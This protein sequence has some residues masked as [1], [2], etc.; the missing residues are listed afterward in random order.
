MLSAKFVLLENDKIFIIWKRAHSIA[1]GWWQAKMRKTTWWLPVLLSGE[2]RQSFTLYNGGT[3]DCRLLDPQQ[4]KQSAGGT[5][6]IMRHLWWEMNN[7]G[8]LSKN[9]I[10]LHL[11]KGPDTKCHLFIS[12]DRSY[13]IYPD[14]PAVCVLFYIVPSGWFSPPDC[15][16]QIHFIFYYSLWAE[17]LP[18]FASS[19]LCFNQRTL[20]SF[21]T[22]L[23][24][25]SLWLLSLSRGCFEQIGPLALLFAQGAP[26][27]LWQGVKSWAGIE[28]HGRYASTTV[29]LPGEYL[30]LQRQDVT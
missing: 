16:S 11:E 5:E 3:G 20:S 10:C 6:Q 12:L 21:E 18:E 26:P 15:K 9:T 30:E 17:D 2:I 7:A 13:L 25:A 27:L 1:H 22:L 29:T 8:I 19:F 4:K 14:F 28:M 24:S 23:M